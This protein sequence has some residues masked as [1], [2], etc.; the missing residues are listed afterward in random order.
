[1]V[2]IA[3][4]TNTVTWN[5]QTKYDGAGIVKMEAALERMA[6]KIDS[7]R[8]KFQEMTVGNKA[9]SADATIKEINKIQEAFSKSYNSMFGMFDNKKLSQALGQ[10]DFTNLFKSLTTGKSGIEGLS[11]QASQFFARVI[12]GAGRINT[13]FASVSGTLE[14]F[15]N[16]FLN[17]ARWGVT[18]SIFQGIMNSIRGSVEYIKELDTSLNNI[19]VVTGYSAE[20][21]KS[22][23]AYA[24]QAAQALGVSTTAFTDAAQLY[25]Q[26]GYNVE[27][28]QK[29]ADLTIKTANVTQADVVETSE[30]ITALI[31]GYQLSID[32]AEK[33]LDGM[34]KVAAASASDLDELATAQERVAS[35]AHMLGVSQEQLTSQISTIVSVTRLAPESVGTALR[36]LYSRFADIELGETLEDGVNLGD[37]SKELQKV[38]INVLDVNGNLRNMG[39]IIEELMG[40]WG[41]LTKTQQQSLGNV[42]AGKRQTNMLAALMEN[43]EMYQEQLE[44]F[45]GAAGTLEEQ[46]EIRME[47]LEAK[48]ASMGAAAEGM[49]SSLIDDEALK[50]VVDTL[51]QVLNLVKQII[52]AIGG[53]GNIAGML[54][55]MLVQGASKQIG[56]GI[57]NFQYNRQKQQMINQNQ[58][59]YVGLMEEIGAQ[60]VRDSKGNVQSLKFEL[61]GDQIMSGTLEK[62]MNS[63]LANF[64]NLKNMSPDEIKAASTR[65]IEMG[66]VIAQGYYHEKSL[67]STMSKGNKDLQ[68]AYNDYINAGGSKIFGEDLGKILDI[69]NRNKTSSMTEKQFK[70]NQEMY[71]NEMKAFNARQDALSK[72]GDLSSITK[73]IRDNLGDQ[74]GREYVQKLFKSFSGVFDEES[75]KELDIYAANIQK[76]RQKYNTI[77]DNLKDEAIVN[78]NKTI[79]AAFGEKIGTKEGELTQLQEQLGQKVKNSES[80]ANALEKAVEAEEAAQKRVDA[81]Y[82]RYTEIGQQDIKGNLIGKNN[83]KQSTQRKNIQDAQSRLDLWTGEQA[84]Y[85]KAKEYADTARK[86]LEQARQKEQEIRSYNYTQADNEVKEAEKALESA[87]TRRSILQQINEVYG[88]IAELQRTKNSLETDAVTTRQGMIEDQ[89]SALQEVGTNISLMSDKINDVVNGVLAQDEANLKNILQSM[90]EDATNFSEGMMG[91][92]D[93]LESFIVANAD[94]VQKQINIL[95]GLKNGY[96]DFFLDTQGERAYTK[97]NFEDFMGKI[98]GSFNQKVL[99]EQTGQRLS[100]FTDN[101]IA[102]I[103]AAARTVE[104]DGSEKVI[105]NALKSI[106]KAINERIAELKKVLGESKEFERIADEIRQEAA[107][108]AQDADEAAAMAEEEARAERERQAQLQERERY[109]ALTNLLGQ[110]SQLGFSI[111][112]M[113]NIVNVI[114]DD[115]LTALEKVQQ[116]FMNLMITAPMLVTSI[117]GIGQSLSSLG[118]FDFFKDLVN[119]SRAT[120]IGKILTPAMTELAVAQEA[121]SIAAG[122]LTVAE[123]MCGASSIEATIAANALT[124]AEAELAIAEEGVAAASTQAAGGVAVFTGAV[125]AFFSTT[126]GF[127]TIVGAIIAGFAALGIAEANARDE[128]LKQNN[129]KIESARQAVETL[130]TIGNDK[131]SLQGIKDEIRE[132][133]E[134]TDELKNTVTQLASAYGVAV[135]AEDLTVAGVERL[136]ALLEKQIELKERAA[137]T[138]LDQGIRAAEE[139]FSSRQLNTFNNR[140]FNLAGRANS[141]ISQLQSQDMLSSLK[142]ANSFGNG[143]NQY[144]FDTTKG[145]GVVAGEI[146]AAIAQLDEKRAAL[147]NQLDRAMGDERENIN[148]QIDALDKARQALENTGEQMG[149]TAENIQLYQDRLNMS[150]SKMKEIVNSSA[151]A[152]QAL[153]RLY[154]DAELGQAL[155]GVGDTTAQMFLDQAF[156]NTR[157]EGTEELKRALAE[158]FRTA[159]VEAA[160]EASSEPISL[161]ADL[162]F[163]WAEASA[164]Q[165][166]GLDSLYSSYEKKLEDGISGFTSQEVTEILAK[167]PG[168][169]EYLTKVGDLYSLNKRALS[170]WNSAT[171]EQSQML[172]EQRGEWVNLTEQNSLLNSLL[173]QT[174]QDFETASDSRKNAL[175]GEQEIYQGLIDLNNQLMYGGLDNISFLDGLNEQF[176]KFQEVVAESGQSFEDFVQTV[177]GQDLS[178]MLVDE[179]YQGL[180]QASR[181]FQSGEQNITDYSKSMKQ[182]ARN[183][184]SLVAAQEGLS[185]AQVDSI[186]SAD[187]LNDAIK[188]NSNVSKKAVQQIRDL[189][190][191][192]KELDAFDA[193]NE[194]LTN[195]FDDAVKFIDDAGNLYKQYI[196]EQGA[197][198]EQALGFVQT[199]TDAMYQTASA[200]QATFD[201]LVG[202]VAQYGNMSREQAAAI[203]ADQAA[204]NS[205]MAGNAAAFGAAMNATMAQSQSAIA[206]IANGITNIISGVM[207]MIGSANANI[208]GSVQEEGGLDTTFTYTGTDGTEQTGRIHVPGFHVSVQ[209][210]GGGGGR[211]YVGSGV[212]NDQYGLAA[213]R[214]QFRGDTSA[215]R[216]YNTKQTQVYNAMKP[217]G[218]DSIYLGASQLAQGL[219]LG[220]V[221]KNNWAPS[222]YSGGS[223][224]AGAR[225]GSGGGGGGGGGGGSPKGGGG[226]GSGKE[227]EPDIMDYEEGEPNRYERVETLLDAIGNDLEKIADEQDR[228]IGRRYQENLQKQVDLIGKQ[229]AL[230][231]QKL[232]IQ[233]EEAAEL[234]EELSSVYGVTFDDEGFISN[235]AQ[236]YRELLDQV[237]NLITQYNSAGSEEAQEQIK[238]QIELA[239][240]ALSEYEDA[241]DRYDELFADGIKQTEKAIQDLRNQIEDLNIDNLTRSL[242]SLKDLKDVEETWVDFENIFD[243]IG[244]TDPFKTA[245]KTADVAIE[246]MKKY[247]DISQGGFKDSLFYSNLLLTNQEDIAK[248]EADGN[249]QLVAWLTNQRKLLQG[250]QGAQGAGTVESGGTGYFDYM[251]QYMDAIGTEW[252]LINATGHGQYFGFGEDEP[253]T[254]ALL[255]FTKEIY[256][257]AT[258]LLEDYKDQAEDLHDAILD[259]VDDINNR[260]D[261][262]LEKY[263]NINDE[264][265]HYLS[266]EELLRG[267]QSYDML[268]KIDQAV[269]ENNKAMINELKQ[270]ISV[271]EDLVKKLPEGSEEW[272]NAN[273]ALIEKQQRLIEMV[274]ETAQK[275]KDIYNRDVA[276]ALDEWT[277][278][279]PLGKDLE[280]MQQEWELIN[281]NADQYYDNVIAAYET[282]KLQNKYLDLLDNTDDLQTQQKITQQMNEQ[283]KYLREKDKLSEY[284]V[285]YA[286]AQLE[287]LQKTIALEDAQRNKNQLKLRRD[288]QGNYSYVYSAN[289]EDT[290]DKENDLLDAQ[291]NAYMLSKE[292]MRQTQ[293]DAL[294]ALVDA[295]SMLNDIWTNANLDLEEKEKRTRIIIDSLKEYL[296]GCAEQLSVSEKNIINDFLGMWDL[297]SEENRARLQEVHDQI[298]AGNV[299]AFDQVD[300]RWN[301]S[302]SEWLQHMD[303]FSLTTDQTF[304]NLVT[305]FE[306]YSQQIDELGNVAEMNLNDLTQSIQGAID[307]T[308]DL[309]NSTAEFVAQLQNDVGIVSDYSDS[310]KNMTDKIANLESGMAQYKEKVAEMKQQ[311]EDALAENAQLKAPKQETYSTQTPNN[312]S[313]GPG[314]TGGEDKIRGYDIGTLVEG[315]TG[316]IWT[317][318]TWGNDPVRRNR[319][320]EKFGDRGNEIH[321][322]VQALYNG[323]PRYGYDYNPHKWETEGWSYYRKFSYDSFDTGGYTGEFHDPQGAGRL[324]VLHSKELVLNEVDTKNILNAV[325]AVRNM[326]TNFRNGAFEDLVQSLNRE[327]NQML[328]GQAVQDTLEQQIHIDAN[329]PNVHDAREI[330]EAI[331][332]L[333]NEIS[334]MAFR[335]R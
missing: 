93:T 329:F 39:T 178:N 23:A 90:L 149:V 222:G 228:L 31:N 57:Q 99:N 297:T 183:A 290:R 41:Q 81:A 162:D 169:V 184:E 193:F 309:A 76:F 59:E 74:T 34:A 38:G 335:R 294:S 95:S 16:S 210:D 77:T 47:S 148:N 269:V 249:K 268:N 22:Y 173:Q 30:H 4:Y 334:Q 261:E 296:A 152:S 292:A 48:M 332:N 117:M 198:A 120:E 208:I 72:A 307:K 192:A 175:Q 291:Q 265:E 232:E 187:S 127:L 58:Q 15:T 317:Y 75:L 107:V 186:K 293:D 122:E 218:Y 163:E 156:S 226:G 65:M 21:M 158:K 61:P 42:I 24:N 199:M 312:P 253:D 214:A 330:E 19:R 40:V 212:S 45:Q 53:G 145:L 311:L 306:N 248:A 33:A 49:W 280:W 207:E 319:M 221:N 137:Q 197:V 241:V 180:K 83:S 195:N 322:A 303:E 176:D 288:T 239:K 44:L 131:T 217:A 166:S 200:S 55:S 284:D 68:S 92:L 209:G 216:R 177:E 201:T 7:N 157:F 84:H 203:V 43:P 105:E 159:L 235:Y 230:Q 246:K 82:K 168:Y 279:T 144:Y 17:T 27:D 271:Y 112:S 143:E 313:P 333:P 196:N 85:K 129:E 328:A 32:E 318:G 245:T 97:D 259:M 54:G 160:E 190:D 64:R 108:H 9:F 135:N 243:T 51:T 257:E 96:K 321:D 62:L 139:N 103:K 142:I 282:Q 126:A 146:Q 182:A 298:I 206:N 11:T 233:K 276:K 227:W 211:G 79:I 121:A 116:V 287:I 56:R 181:Q 132:T 274:D 277:K 191:S 316:N 299:D 300:T 247:F 251:M 119:F 128:I 1:M 63:T 310:L 114:S 133:G 66:K 323:H 194:A 281:R 308:N 10:T 67:I 104:D 100:V 3:K 78:P 154:S 172:E 80:A 254:Q 138:E 231:K 267:D 115:Q 167:N 174:A 250:A 8:S 255:D 258:S 314:D 225:P 244:E 237:N 170:E 6:S 155:S 134:V 101:M 13:E 70:E 270:V 302:I 2:P 102:D 26:N 35:T 185:D 273:E 46:Q 20:D 301:T 213:A 229:I 264:L 326:T 153:E 315:I 89:T 223:P 331:L 202:I 124:A 113:G 205:F 60:A 260:I 130:N 25:A 266:L 28:Q 106:M 12:N 240:E 86:D 171:Y 88:E 111:Q 304:Q 161:K 224:A 325:N 94:A 141:Y 73:G 234:R 278:D 283:L 204:L 110:V 236:K 238:E 87:R 286:N 98:S 50:G 285:A 324:A 220:Q 165:I 140:S 164:E 37:V 151:S 52:D 147:S 36:T 123:E 305:N 262:R 327:G 263:E 275:I 189:S 136:N 29:L 188:Q 109:T 150:A 289:P 215:A 91:P 219:G 5:L 14:K 252:A 71:L 272:K 242:E 320:I 18:A 179:L 125:K 69:N 118:V 295:K 256:E